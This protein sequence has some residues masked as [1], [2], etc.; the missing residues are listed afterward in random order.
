MRKGLIVF[1][2]LILGIV[3][4]VLILRNVGLIQ[5]TD[6]LSL[7][8]IGELMIVLVTFFLGLVV[9]GALKWQKIMKAVGFNVSSF[10]RIFLAKWVGY[11]ISYLTPAVFFGGGPVRF[12]IIKEES[13]HLD[14]ETPVSS[15]K[16]ISSIILDKLILFLVSSVYFFAG[17]FFILAYLDLS[18]LTQIVLFSFLF[19]VITIFWF[20][21]HRAKKISSEKGFF[22]VLIERFYLNKLSFVK[23]N[24]GKVCEI[25]QEIVDFFKSSKKKIWEILLL[26]ALEIA[27]VFLSYWLVVF[28]IGKNLEIPKL[29]AIKSMID[30]SYIV[31][32]PAALGAMEI[33][34]AFLF[35][36]LGFGLA[37]G[38][39]FS[40]VLRGLSLIIIFLGLLILVWLQFKYLIKKIINF[41]SRFALEINKDEKNSN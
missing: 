4:F 24:Q 27:F 23:K 32:L 12:H 6:A 22:I 11:S 17:V 2:L 20:L 9:V 16:I 8:S 3:L 40:L 5:V 15:A 30:A 29:F 31:P 26:S 18:W 28:F 21:L 39:A 33:S 34:Q 35:K 37:T 7:L 41:F 14:S 36:L 13:D 1:A 25:E 19:L 10:S 38:L